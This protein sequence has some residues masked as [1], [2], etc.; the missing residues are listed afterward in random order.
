ML[1]EIHQMLAVC[2]PREGEAGALQVGNL[3]ALKQELERVYVAVG[4]IAPT[5]ESVMASIQHL[6]D[7]D[8]YEDEYGGLVCLHHCW[9][10]AEITLEQQA[11]LW[12]VK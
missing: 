11:P 3:R 10:T 8:D 2:G 1:E 12:L 5:R 6:E 4:D 7:I 9:Y